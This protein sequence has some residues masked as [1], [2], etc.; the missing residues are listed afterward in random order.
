ML[1]P[2]SWPEMVWSR[3]YEWFLFY[4]DVGQMFFIITYLFKNQLR[5]T[6]ALIQK[7][8]CAVIFVRKASCAYLDSNE[9]LRLQTTNSISNTLSPPFHKSKYIKMSSSASRI[10][11]S[12]KYADDLNEYR[13]VP[14]HPPWSVD[15]RKCRFQKSKRV[16]FVL[17]IT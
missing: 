8:S 5:H 3:I 12:E 7:I 17:R 11:Y 6:I 9:A 16:K 13:W 2:E 14:H 1:L 4:T 10:E 15:F